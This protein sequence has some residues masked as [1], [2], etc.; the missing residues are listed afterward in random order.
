L[1]LR[2]LGKTAEAEARLKTLLGRD[3]WNAP[4]LNELGLIKI[5]QKNWNEAKEWFERA[6]GVQPD[7]SIAYYNL[8]L[9]YRNL[10]Q[11]A[12]SAANFEKYLKANPAASDAAKVRQWITSLRASSLHK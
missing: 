8:G 3:A 7:Y 1:A 10:N 12:E 9:A 2:R 11:P 4:G 6:V 5:E